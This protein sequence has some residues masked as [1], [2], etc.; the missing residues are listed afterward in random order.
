MRKFVL[1]AFLAAT[2]VTAAGCNDDDDCKSESA[3][4]F[5][6]AKPGGGSGGGGSGSRGGGKSGKRGG[7]GGSGVTNR[8]QCDDDD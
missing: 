1:L 5:V 8:T 4:A 7:S 2:L 6:M 3:P